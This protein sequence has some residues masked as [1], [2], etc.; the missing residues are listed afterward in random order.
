MVLT[1]PNFLPILSEIH[2]VPQNIVSVLTFW[3]DSEGLLTEGQHAY[4]S[5]SEG[6]TS[7]GFAVVVFG[8]LFASI[9]SR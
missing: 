9:D 8:E 7:V 5:P 2:P 4:H 3:L 1:M 6:D